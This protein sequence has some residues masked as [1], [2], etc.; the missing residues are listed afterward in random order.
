[1]KFICGLPSS[2]SPEYSSPFWCC[3]QLLVTNGPRARLPHRSR[4]EGWSQLSC[5]ARLLPVPRPPVVSDSYGQKSLPGCPEGKGKTKTVLILLALYS[6]AN[7]PRAEIQR[8]SEYLGCPGYALHMCQT[9]A[10][11]HTLTDTAMM[12]G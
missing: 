1:M 9:N 3:C 8:D 6:L 5:Q 12:N 7:R 4:T 11:I 2:V 10:S